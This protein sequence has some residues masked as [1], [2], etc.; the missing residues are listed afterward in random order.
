MRAFDEWTRTEKTQRGRRSEQTPERRCPGRPRK[1]AATHRNRPARDLKDMKRLRESLRKHGSPFDVGPPQPLLVH[2]TSKVQAQAEVSASMLSWRAQGEKA[3]T[4]FQKRVCQKDRSVAFT[5]PLQKIAL[6]TFTNRRPAKASKDKKDAIYLNT[7]ASCFLRM[8]VLNEGREEEKITTEEL[9]KY[10]LCPLPF[11]LCNPMGVMHS[12]AKHKLL[13]KI[14]PDATVAEGVEGQN[15]GDRPHESRASEC[16]QEGKDEVI[17]RP[18]GQ[19]CALVPEI[20]KVPW[21]PNRVLGG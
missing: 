14:F 7:A 1:H 16:R 11:A 13:P 17:R 18:R 8:V 15:T 2:L 6:R 10:E 9:S 19:D 20:C 4:D 3:A 5:T 12:T 21:I